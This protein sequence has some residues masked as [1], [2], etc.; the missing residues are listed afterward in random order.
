MMGKISML[1]YWSEMHDKGCLSNVFEE[2]TKRYKDF[3]AV[4]V[5]VSIPNT[6]V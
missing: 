1:A 3:S 6:I 2:G 4:S 5:A